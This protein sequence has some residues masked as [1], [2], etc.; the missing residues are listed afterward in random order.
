MRW[1]FGMKC[2]CAVAAAL[3]LCGA[4]RGALSQTSVLL[5]VSDGEIKLGEWN[6]NFAGARA[7]ADRFNIPLLVFYG[8]LSCG[9]CEEL[10]NP[11]L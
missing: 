11:L 3:S 1:N 8:G 7:I 6:G 9:K 5:P 10:Q 4:A 2:I